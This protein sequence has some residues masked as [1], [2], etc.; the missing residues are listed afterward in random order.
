MVYKGERGASVSVLNQ[1]QL[2]HRAPS[3]NFRPVFSLLSIPS[4][5]ET[6]AKTRMEKQ[7]I[8][9]HLC[10]VNHGTTLGEMGQTLAVT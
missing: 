1:I 4:P 2:S 3:V 6:D 9:D 5:T 10:V 7:K 8:R